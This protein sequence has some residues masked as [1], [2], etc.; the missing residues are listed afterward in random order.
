MS[1]KE[2]S[3]CTGMENN[4]PV[5]SAPTPIGAYSDNIIL[6]P[7]IGNTIQIDN[8]PIQAGNNLTSTLSIILN[9]INDL[10]NQIDT[11][12]ERIPAEEEEPTPQPEPY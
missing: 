1:I 12:E 3:V 2:I 9:K 4:Q 8:T 10:Q 11:L 5:W 7:S 6:S